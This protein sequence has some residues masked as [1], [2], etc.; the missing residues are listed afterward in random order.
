MF[1]KLLSTAPQIRY[2]EFNGI[3]CAHVFELG[4]FNC[5]HE[6]PI[7]VGNSEI[8]KKWQEISQEL[9]ASLRCRFLLVCHTRTVL[10]AKSGSQE[11]VEHFG[12]LTEQESEAFAPS[13]FVKVA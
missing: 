4:V 5:A 7:K 11:L 6:P 9:F 10:T 2:Y 12:K 3:P 13:V 8:L 1:E